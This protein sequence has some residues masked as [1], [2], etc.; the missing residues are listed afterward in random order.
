MQNFLKIFG[1]PASPQPAAKTLP[2]VEEPK[3]CTPITAE[4]LCKLAP[5]FRMQD[6]T[7]KAA[8][9]TGSLGV[10][11]SNA[12]WKCDG[13]KYNFALKVA[14]FQQ[15]KMHQ[16]I[17]DKEFAV[18]KEMIKYVVKILLIFSAPY[19]A[20]ILPCAAVDK[21]EYHYYYAFPKMHSD[22][23]NYIQERKAENKPIS[24]DQKFVWLRKVA[25]AIQA[26]HERNV[27]HR[28]IKGSNVLVCK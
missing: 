19:H 11:V 4:E 22:L 25:R 9:S 14:Q 10:V 7:K 12:E 17:L 6:V 15:N 21:D 23:F 8:I 13:K 28:D 16:Q 2:V 24:W 18:A 27:I 5:K 26:L 20:N 1:V 3:E